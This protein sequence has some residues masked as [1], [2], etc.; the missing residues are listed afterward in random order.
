M[1]QRDRET[2]RFHTDQTPSTINSLARIRGQLPAMAPAET[3]VARWVLQQPERIIHMSMAEVAQECGVSDT[4]VLRFCR[5]AGFHGYMD[6]KLSMARDAAS[7][8]QMIHDDISEDD[9]PATAARKVFMSNAQA[10]YDTLEMLDEQGLT[11]AVAMLSEARHILV[12]GVGTSGPIVRDMYNKLIRLGLSCSA[13]TDSYLQLME[14]ALLGPEDVA[15]AI[16]QSGSSIDPV[17]TLQQAK[18][19][20]ARTICITGNAK[21]PITQ[22]SDITLLSVSH[23]RRAEAIASRIAQITIVDALYVILSLR[24]MEEAVRNERLIWDAVIPKTF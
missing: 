11:Q 17:M 20:G 1:D 2:E 16:S 22:H 7:P 8:T 18:R 3:R 5:G 14:A 9:D 15:V 6:L 23:E 13:Q 21:S 19:H 24:N 4:T 12:V 10:L